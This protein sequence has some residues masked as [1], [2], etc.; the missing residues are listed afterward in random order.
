MAKFCSQCGASISEANKFCPGC[1]RALNHDVNLVKPSA[2]TGPPKIEV[3][4]G[5]RNNSKVKQSPLCLI[6]CLGLFFVVVATTI[7]ILFCCWLDPSEKP[8]TPEI[9]QPSREEHF[10]WRE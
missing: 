10:S 6:T 2:K 9:D 5:S 4:N 3:V 7:L 1:G 8:S